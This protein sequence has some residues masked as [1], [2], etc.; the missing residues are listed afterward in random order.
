M[1]ITTNCNLP[2]AE[3]LLIVDADVLRDLFAAAALSGLTGNFA[4]PAHTFSDLVAKHAYDYADA[5]LAA[6][7]AKKETA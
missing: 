3:D 6:R 1:I 7:N 5:M 2:N 4:T